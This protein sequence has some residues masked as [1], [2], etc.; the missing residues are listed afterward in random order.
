M[1]L[2]ILEDLR[3]ENS[4]EIDLGHVKLVGAL[5]TVTKSKNETSDQDRKIDPLEK[6]T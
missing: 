1:S 3:H 6:H 4:P 5:R 2:K